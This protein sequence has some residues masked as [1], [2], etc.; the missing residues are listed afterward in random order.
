MRLASV[1]AAALSTIPCDATELNY[2]LVGP[3]TW[4][5]E[6]QFT[7]GPLNIN[8]LRVDITNPRTTVEA[9]PGQGRLFQGETVP[10]TVQ[11][12]VEPGKTVVL[13]GVNGDFWAMTPKPYWS[14]GPLVSDGWIHR[15]G[16]GKRSVFA[17]TR[18]EQVHI[19]PVTFTI[20]LIAGKQKIPVESVNLPSLQR[21]V[22]FTPP[23]GEELPAS[24]A[25]RYLLKLE[26]PELLPNQP[27]Q[28]SVELI[29]TSDAVAIPQG[30]VILSIPVDSKW[31][32]ILGTAKELTIDARM[33]ELNGVV[34]SCLG[35]GPRILHQGKIAI[36]AEKEGVGRS[37]VAAKHPRTAAGVSHDG[38][39]VYLVTVDG[40]Q[41]RLSV[42]MDLHELASYMHT[43]GCSEALNLDGG[44][45]TTMVVGGQVVNQP[46]DLR[47][48]RPVTNSLLVV[49]SPGTGTI[50]V[51]Q[52]IPSGEPLVVPAGTQVRLQV[53]AFDERMTPL[54][55]PSQ[56]NLKADVTGGLSVVSIAS[57]RVTLQLPENSSEGKL[58]L[59]LGEVRA[60]MIIRGT[61]L[62]DVTIQPSV[63]LLDPGERV[64]MAIQV[65]AGKNPVLV[66]PEMIHTKTG[67][68]VV[69]VTRTSVEALEAGESLL[70]L[71]LGTAIEAVPSFVG[72]ARSVPIESF[73]L[74]P[75][76]SQSAGSNLLAEATELV[77]DKEQKKE[78]T[79]AVRLKYSMMPAGQ[80][81]VVVPVQQKI[82][83]KPV[84]LAV[85]VY[86]DG[87]EASLRSTLVDSEGTTFTADFTDGGREITWDQEW[88]RATCWVH[89]LTPLNSSM[90]ASPQFPVTLQDLYL[91][92]D[93]EA[94]KT[95]GTIVLDA[96]EA[97]YPPAPQN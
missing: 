17:V 60:E 6:Q 76:R 48:P 28:A 23:F 93:Q 75:K 57:D 52:L 85:W 58:T 3:G 1:L 54:Q 90:P 69:S 66:Q 79:G 51:L 14:A 71:R 72:K 65:E 22:L 4:H 36:N 81:R 12:E 27:A 50:S 74:L 2:R 53:R 7:S 95:S 8:V 21:V 43:L 92:Q 46:S 70:H 40:R 18:D 44:G 94:L 83:E 73:D 24:T 29:D 13:G 62:D 15:L 97:L 84:K 67:D 56:L 55:L 16:S 20:H 86:G 77:L 49:A 31:R 5:S 88:R 63:L 19:G 96:L 64:E 32:S 61:R 59:S 89:E 9:E 80:G 35:G 47:G 25:T 37:F 11:R 42:G 82:L 34:T 87:K 41:P 78:G 68:N 33:E 45:S 30:S 26:N 91:Q 10:A 39:T 38:R